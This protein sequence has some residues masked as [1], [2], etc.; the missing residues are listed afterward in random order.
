MIIN[1]IAAMAPNRVIGNKNT[2]PRHYADDLK[3]FKNLTSWHTVVMWYNTFLSIGK[4]LP[5]RRNI[6]L[7]SRK[8]DEIEAY[9]SIDDMLKK[10][11]ADKVDEIFIIGWASIYWQFIDKADFIYL[12]QIHKDYEGDTY[13][14]VF[15]DKYTEIDR[16][17][18][19]EMD[20][21]KYKKN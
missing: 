16:E 6:I 8:I 13:F 20:F 18:H 17:K 10:L 4:P 1:I 9:T 11:E 2:L 3:H 14:P 19:E 21:I 5:N 12:T 7:S 15:E